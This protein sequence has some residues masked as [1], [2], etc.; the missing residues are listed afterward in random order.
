MGKERLDGLST[1]VEEFLQS[2]RDASYEGIKFSLGER[3][4]IETDI[5]FVVNLKDVGESFV[6]RKVSDTLD[7]YVVMSPGNFQEFISN[8]KRH[9][10]Y[11]DLKS[12]FMGHKI[13]QKP[14]ITHPI[15]DW[16]AHL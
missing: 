6:L 7:Q 3:I 12:K 1:T 13:S 8:F 11:G 14:M 4:E 10:G 9:D 15:I 16:D 2:V 5:F